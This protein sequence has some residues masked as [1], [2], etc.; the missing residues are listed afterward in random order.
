MKIQNFSST[1]EGAGRVIVESRY[2]LFTGQLLASAAFAFVATSLTFR[3][4]WGV[5]F[6][7]LLGGLVG[8]VFWR[9]PCLLVRDVAKGKSMTIETHRHPAIML[10]LIVW[11]A[12]ALASIV[13]LDPWTSWTLLLAT[14]TLCGSVWFGGE[15]SPIRA[16]YLGLGQLIQF[17]ISVKRQFQRSGQIMSFHLENRN[18]NVWAIVVPIVV[19]VVFAALYATSNSKL[20]SAWHTFLT[21]LSLSEFW[22]D[23]LSF[24]LQFFLWS[25]LG[26]SLVYISKYIRRRKLVTLSTSQVVPDE[27]SGSWSTLSISLLLVNI[28]AMVLN[29]TD[30]STTWI[31]EVSTSGAELKRGVH[32]GTSSIITAVILASGVLLYAI[33][34]PT[35]DFNRSK[36]LGIAWL[37]QNGVMVA[38]VALRNFHY[39]D[40]Y[41]L[42][43]KRI[44]VW[45][46][47]ILTS[48]GLVFLGRALLYGGGILSLL[49]RQSWAVYLVLAFAALPNWPG[50][51]TRYNLSAARMH[52]DQ[53]YLMGLT[54]YNLSTW[55]TLNPEN[56]WLRQRVEQMSKVG[57]RGNWRSGIYDW[58]EWDY[59]QHQRVRVVDDFYETLKL[60][61]Q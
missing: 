37:A 14:I 11:C 43:Y 54:P 52:I 32:A 41:G 34:F 4:A 40:A 30:G 58:R 39:T 29:V 46:F 27:L 5:N 6:P 31:G 47:L 8:V 56:P 48:T 2:R 26:A 42:T 44:G 25:L 51:I 20:S 12:L 57:Y 13:H 23:I 16:I 15:V 10:Q 19:S 59:A 28:L 45:L 3:A 21:W 7:L 49:R 61:K 9:K 22:I 55:I 33:R 60:P 24:V 38:T 53:R 18:T 1:Y 35:K 36:Q 50:L 17:P